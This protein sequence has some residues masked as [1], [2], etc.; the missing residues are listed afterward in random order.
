MAD[1]FLPL[2]ITL[3]FRMKEYTACRILIYSL[4]I[5]TISCLEPYSPPA[6]NEEIDILVVDGHINAADGSASVQLSKAYPLSENTSAIP[7][8]NA[9]VQIE[10]E[11]GTV[12]TL[13]EES[14]GNY[15]LMNMAVILST[16]YRLSILTDREKKY[17][18]DYIEL[19]Q[20]PQIDSITW[21]LSNGQD[22]LNISVNTHGN[23]AVNSSYYQWNFVETWEYSAVYPVFARILNKQVV[24]LDVN[25]YKCWISKPST[26]INIATSKHLNEDLISD[27]LL[28]FIP[29]GSQKLS[30]RYSILVQQRTLSREAYN[31]WTQ[32]KKT[33]ENLGSLF[34]P[35]PTQV[36]GNI[37]SADGSD[38]PVLGYFDG[39]VVAEKRLFISESDLPPDFHFRP[40]FCQVDSIPIGDVAN[41][42]NILL[43]GSYGQPFTLGYTASPSAGCTDCRS[44]GGDLIKPDFW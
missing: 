11:N 14:D 13:V 5:L 15:K 12:Y 30:R 6:I 39:G 44:G 8:L 40:P 28:V 29:K 4:F 7:E 22:G 17:F 41:Y 37:H 19:E 23:K 18:S 27:H 16:K 3:N 25:P 26:E 1:R 21:K 42:N 32:L 34:D 43:I 38:E 2:R 10:D 36:L 20:S 9:T 31:F 24:S 35:L 33:T